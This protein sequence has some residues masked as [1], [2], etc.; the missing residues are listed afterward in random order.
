MLKMS[1]NKSRGGFST[2]KQLT[3]IRL[4]MFCF[5]LLKRLLSFFLVI[6]SGLFK[7]FGEAFLRYAF[8]LKK[9][10]H[11]SRH[12]SGIWR[13]F[14]WLFV[15]AA[16]L[17]NLPALL[18]RGLRGG[19]R[20]LSEDVYKS[21][22]LIRAEVNNLKMSKKQIIFSSLSFAIFLALIVLP[23][24]FYSQ[25]R[26][27][28]S[29]KESAVFSAEAGTSNLLSAKEALS[30]FDLLSAQSSFTAAAA[31][32][33][34]ARQR[35]EK[36]DAILLQ[37][38]GFLP[39]EQA[40][41]A[42]SGR[43]ILLAGELSAGLGERLTRILSPADDQGDSANGFL[44]QSLLEELR[45]AAEEAQQ[46]AK[47]LE[48]VK[49]K[50]LPEEYRELFLEMSSQAVLLSTGLREIVDI[51]E[52]VLVL[53]GADLDRRYMLV[54]Q[55]NAEKRGSGGFVGSF[56]VIDVS[57][58]EVVKITT[59]SG[60]SY[61][62][63]AGLYR[64]LAAPPPLQLLRGRWYFWDA[65]WWPDWPKSA[66]KLMW[67]YE[68][69]NGPTVDGVISFT[70]RVLEELLVL[71]GP[72]DL[73]EDYG[74]V[75]DAENFWLVTQSFAE[76]KFEETNEPKKIIGDLLD[77]LL[78][79]LGEDMSPQLALNLVALLTDMAS[80]KHVMIYVNDQ[81]AQS[82]FRRLG[83]AG[84]MRQAKQDYLMVANTNIGG[85][86]TDRVID[87]TITHKATIQTDGS[88][89]VDL[90][91]KREHPGIKGQDFTGVRN[92]NWLRV[93]VPLGSQLLDGVGFISPDSRYFKEV[94]PSWEIDP[95]LWPEINAEIEPLSKTKIYEEN[96]FTVFANWSMI[97][98]GHTAVLQL[99]YRLPFGMQARQ[100]DNFLTNL[101]Q[102]L[103]LSH[104]RESY[105]LLVQKQPG[106]ERTVFQSFVTYPLNRRLLWNYPAAS[107]STQ[108]LE[109]EKPLD[110]DIFSAWLFEY[111]P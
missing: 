70:P 74:V 77:K 3:L 47:E 97:D 50:D 12:H 66:Q 91:V 81:E 111:N 103:G 41:M 20:A 24:W 75:I 85:E 17:L 110:R 2:F 9:A 69:S 90:T 27:A 108:K 5:F 96:G 99:R 42:S 58:G 56:S 44:V 43:S 19:G 45:P 14:R 6:L 52:K 25:W 87:E 102:K 88:I 71:V 18:F 39:S 38:A 98:P 1:N 35:L 48:K 94:D 72:I 92:V 82:V 73:T 65:N 34:L 11:Y 23:F 105:S 4:L 32:F 104:Q 13:F 89:I 33:S 67:F 80:Q 101:L 59:P 22:G 40:K 51:G 63:E 100:E 46:L 62:T 79:K 37:L 60:G 26:L 61:D 84:E 15:P 21:S 8:E 107:L 78:V 68:Q 49:P 16:A 93:Y 29:V 53:F 54:F 55:N 109:F 64:L 36:I 86:K 30:S 76:Q 7:S 31:D 106:A 28:S 95:L 57:Q 10:H 83:W